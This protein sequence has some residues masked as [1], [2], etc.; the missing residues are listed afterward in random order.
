ME[1]NIIKQTYIYKLCHIYKR[2]EWQQEVTEE[3]LRANKTFYL[4]TF[5]TFNILEIDLDALKPVLHT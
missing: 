3:F 5:I 1:P 4:T 2:K